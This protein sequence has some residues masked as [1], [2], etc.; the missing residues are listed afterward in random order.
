MSIMKDGDQQ[1]KEYFIENLQK[2]VDMASKKRDT[3]GVR[4]DGN[5]VHEH[6]GEGYGICGHHLNRRTCKSIRTQGT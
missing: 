2:A 6:R 1:T 5:A 3:V 4:D